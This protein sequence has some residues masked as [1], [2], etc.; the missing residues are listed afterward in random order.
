MNKPTFDPADREALGQYLLYIADALHGLCA[1]VGRGP[2]QRF[3]EGIS[4]ED[5][6][7]DATDIAARRLER[8]GIKVVE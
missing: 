8:N 1:F 7:G 2:R 5:M 3:G 6:P 4:Y